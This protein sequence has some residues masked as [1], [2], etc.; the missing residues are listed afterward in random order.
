MAGY[1]RLNYGEDPSQFVEY[2]DGVNTKERASTPCQKVAV[3]IH[4][5]FWRGTYDLALMNELGIF[6]ASS[7]DAVYNAEYRRLSGGGGWPT[8][9]DD[10]VAAIYSIIN[11]VRNRYQTIA[12]LQIFLVGHSAGGHL[13][14]LAASYFTSQM[15]DQISFYG[16]SLGGVLDL[17]IGFSERIGDGVVAEFLGLRSAPSSDLL[18]DASPKHRLNGGEHLLVVTGGRDN[19][20]PT[21]IANSF[22]QRAKELEADLAFADFPSEDHMDLISTTSNSIALVVDYI[23]S[24]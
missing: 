6:L 1:V 14:A 7:V 9:F 4:G 11:D 19:V 16:I 5:G 18:M 22:I 20:V 21:S 17:E 24:R 23:K 10:V 2:F 8:T 12:P 13:S 15:I 3:L